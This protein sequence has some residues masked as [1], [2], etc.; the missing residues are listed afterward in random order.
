MSGRRQCKLG[1]VL[2]AERYPYDPVDRPRC[3]Y[4]IRVG[5]A[6][7]EDERGYNKQ[8]K[9]GEWQVGNRLKPFKAA[10]YFIAVDTASHGG[11]HPIR[12]SRKRR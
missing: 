8:R 7:L 12:E 3:F 10:T 4:D 1:N 5:C 11:A 6:I 9:K 2:R